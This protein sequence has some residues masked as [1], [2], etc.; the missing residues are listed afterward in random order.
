MFRQLDMSI[1]AKECIH[2]YFQEKYKGSGLIGISLLA[3][4]CHEI[5][6][7]ILVALAEMK[8]RNE[9]EIIERYFCPEGHVIEK[10]SLPFCSQCNAEYSYNYIILKIF[11]QPLIK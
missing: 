2:T 6:G 3:E 10:G 8:E 9:V 1:T 7:L 11:V 4:Y 5:E